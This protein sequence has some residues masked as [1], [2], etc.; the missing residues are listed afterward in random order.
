[1]FKKVGLGLLGLSSSYGFC[2]TWTLPIWSDVHKASYN[3]LVTR[4]TMSTGSALAYIIPPLC[5]TKYLNLYGRMYECEH[6]IKGHG[7]I[8]REW[9]I[10]HPRT[11]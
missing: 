10:Y 11:F 2:R 7:A 6:G 3:E 1:M 9:G 4:I 8:W 5:F